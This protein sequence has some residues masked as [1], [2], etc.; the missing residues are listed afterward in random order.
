MANNNNEPINLN[1]INEAVCYWLGYQ[2]TI[3]R[4]RLI[5]EASLRYPIA[6]A[7]TSGKIAISKIYLEKGHPYFE[8]KVVD[9]FL[10]NEKESNISME[11]IDLEAIS[12]IFELKL[13]KVDT[14]NQFG[15]EKKR[16]IDDILRLAYFNLYSK[17]DAY[18]LICGTYADFKNYFIGDK[19]EKTT[20]KKDDIDILQTN[21]RQGTSFINQVEFINPKEWK[22]ENSL[23]KD[24]FNFEVGSQK[25]YIFKIDE[26]EIDD[27]KK[28]KKFGLKSFQE[29]YII[30]EKLIEYEEKLSIKTTCMA[31][32]PFESIPSRMHACAIWKVEAEN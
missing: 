23:Y 11:S 19:I 12:A 2:F 3:G 20:I 22:T 24:Y 26:N 13:S 31:I 7:I 21:E 17:K 5:H 27:T 25:K 14:G 8:D 30:K 18:F 28:Q 6:D 16:V 4:E 10:L 15:E 9:I 1:S 32:T 29:R